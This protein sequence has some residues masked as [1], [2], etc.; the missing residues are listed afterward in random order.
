[1]SSWN[2]TYEPA[3][4]NK[5]RILID[6]NM[7]VFT[8][9]SKRGYNNIKTGM[10]I[11]EI[12]S[13]NEVRIISINGGDE[14]DINALEGKTILKYLTDFDNPTTHLK[15][16]VDTNDIM[17]RIYKTANGKYVNCNT[18]NSRRIQKIVCDIVNKL[19][20]RFERVTFVHV[21]SHQG[22]YGNDMADMA[23]K[24]GGD[25]TYNYMEIEYLQQSCLHNLNI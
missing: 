12:N 9:G 15:F 13:L 21:W 6:P 23:A 17:T 18:S 11:V 24:S 25:L 16:I 1:M 3:C 2:F 14:Y 4:F 10:G 7:S 19:K 5:N 22:N 8:D 20:N